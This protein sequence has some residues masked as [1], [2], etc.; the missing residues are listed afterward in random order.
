MIIPLERVSSEAIM[1]EKQE[2]SQQENHSES[3]RAVLSAWRGIS[4]SFQEEDS[5][6]LKDINMQMAFHSAHKI[7]QFTSFLAVLF[8]DFFCYV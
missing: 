1:G 5:S 7:S 8:G 6:T 2:P 4:P 3:Q